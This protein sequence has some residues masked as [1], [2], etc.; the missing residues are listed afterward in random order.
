MRSTPLAFVLA[1]VAAF[2]AGNILVE[3]NPD[4]P[5]RVVIYEDLQCSDCATFRAMLDAQILPKFGSR[6][7]FEHRDFPL[8]RH[9]WARRAAIASRYFAG[10]QPEFAVE[11]RRYALANLAEITAENFEGKLSAWA[12]DHG[13]DASNAIAAL[14]SKEFADAVQ[15]DYEDGVARGIAHTP[16]VFVG[17]EPFIETFTFEEI[18]GSLEK[19]IRGQ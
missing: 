19:A 1:G 7:A 11:W 9:K 12:R 18:A 14:G 8:P 3:G 4:S 17:D 13:L 5:V 15:S 16:T 10:I 6:A 2:G